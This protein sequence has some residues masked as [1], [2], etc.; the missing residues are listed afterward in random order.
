MAPALLDG[1]SRLDPL[2]TRFSAPA[3]ASVWLPLLDPAGGDLVKASGRRPGILWGGGAA[4]RG[5][6]GGVPRQRRA[7]R[8]FQ[9]YQVQIPGWLFGYMATSWISTWCDLWGRDSGLIGHAGTAI[10]DLQC[11]REKGSH[12]AALDRSARNLQAAPECF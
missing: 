7:F 5:N 9:R 12:P 4:K 3:G 10:E 2:I 11:D 6:P 1:C 8:G